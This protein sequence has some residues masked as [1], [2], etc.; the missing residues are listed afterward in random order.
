[1][2]STMNN[3]PIDHLHSFLLVL[4]AVSRI[5]D[6]LEVTTAAIK[7]EV[8]SLFIKMVKKVN[9]RHMG[10]VSKH[11]LLIHGCDTTITLEVSKDY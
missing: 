10:L 1:M 9:E 11:S 2:F 5:Q 7:G 8:V 6:R 4:Y 3:R